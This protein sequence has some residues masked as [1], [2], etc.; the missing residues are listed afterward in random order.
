MTLRSALTSLALFLA[1][2]LMLSALGSAAAAGE[3]HH[4]PK[5][6]FY[7]PKPPCIKF[8]C[9]CPMP[10]S[11]ETLEHFGYYPNVLDRL[12]VSS[13]PFLLPVSAA[14]RCRCAGC[15]APRPGGGATPSPQGD[16]QI[17]RAEVALDSVLRRIVETAS[18]F[19]RARL[20]SRQGEQAF[21]QQ[22]LFVEEPFVRGRAVLANELLVG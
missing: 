14:N 5:T 21:A 22:A 7:R 6:V 2:Y 15:R 9:V 4:C 10:I 8:K 13:R 11:C 12:A 16:A 18:F 3:C 20:V 19:R 17:G 1:P